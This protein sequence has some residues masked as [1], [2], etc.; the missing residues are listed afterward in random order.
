VILRTTAVV[1]FGFSDALEIKVRRRRL[2][3]TLRRTQCEQMTSGLPLKA[4]LAQCSRHFAF[5]PLP[6]VA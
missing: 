6:A 2:W 3:V 4:D 5:V 1:H